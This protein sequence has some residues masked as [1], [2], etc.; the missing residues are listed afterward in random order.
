MD[1]QH[2]DPSQ[3]SPR[4]KRHCNTGSSGLQPMN[5]TVE[6]IMNLHKLAMNATKNDAVQNE[7]NEVVVSMSHMSRMNHMSLATWS[8]QSSS[9]ESCHTKKC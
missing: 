5:E 6:D 8:L 4:C 7:I 1:T 9:H 2:T 3:V